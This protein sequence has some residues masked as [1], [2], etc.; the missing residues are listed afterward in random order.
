M[1][2]S[3]IKLSVNEL[4]GSFEIK[5][6]GFSWVSDGRR[7]Y[8]ILRK[9]VKNRYIST[10]RSLFCAPVR[11]F[12]YT[13]TGI[14]VRLGGYIAFGKRIDFTLVLKAEITGPDTVVFSLNAENET[15]CDIR[16]VCFPAPFNSKKSGSVS[17]H[18]DPMRQGFIMP[19]GYK[20]NFI[21][22]FAYANYLRK[23][24]TGD[25]YMP[26]WGR[27]CDGR[28]FTAIAKPL[29]TPVCSPRSAGTARLLTPC[30]GAP[31]SALSAMKGGCASSFTSKWIIIPPRRITELI[32][33][34]AASW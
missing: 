32:S 8:I 17:Y 25:A 23:I 9:R 3:N 12:E 16:A 1:K 19:D 7:P 6:R 15:G 11:K 18:I 26:I 24:N 27:V 14:T 5:H 33:T 34:A 21:S 4:T 13:D 2:K 31:R 20:K 30:I 28:G 29:T 10:Y 22:T